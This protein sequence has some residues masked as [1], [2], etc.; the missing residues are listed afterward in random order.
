MISEDSY[1]RT[2]P[3]LSFTRKITIREI[4]IVLAVCAIPIHFWSIYNTLRELPGW[5]M[6]MDLWDAIG[7]IAYTQVFALVESLI[8]WAALVFLGLILPK[9]W[10]ADRFVAQASAMVGVFSIWILARHYL[11][12]LYPTLDQGA[13]PFLIV[14][15]TL[16][17]LIL[18][19]MINRFTRL[20]IALMSIA[21]RLAVLGFVY[22]LLDVASL[23]IILTRMVS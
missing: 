3:K 15:I 4:G 11:F 12:E 19:F 2:T 20:N 9:R 21:G 10:F 13:R 17:F 23:L 1:P 22:L 8:L 16:S 6:R 14:I 5:L 18:W 7:A